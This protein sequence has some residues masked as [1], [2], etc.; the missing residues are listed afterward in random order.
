M[1]DF[2]RDNYETYGKELGLCRFG[3]ASDRC[4]IVFDESYLEVIKNEGKY[5][6]GIL[7]G[8]W[9]IHQYN[10]K[11][12][13]GIKSPFILRGE[14]WRKGRMAINPYLFNIK[15]AQSYLGAINKTAETV[16]TKFEEYASI[17]KLDKF[18]EFAAFDMF[19]AASLGLQVNSVAGEPWAVDL[20]ERVNGSF[21]VMS[22]VA[23]NCPYSK[24][25][26]F[27]FKQW[28]KFVAKWKA[29]REASK[30]LI[31]RALEKGEGDGKG[32]MHGFMNDPDLEISSTE[33]TEMNLILTLAAADTTSS[34]INNVLTN[35]S[36]HPDIQDKVR[37][38]FRR[39]LKGAD[40]DPD[41]KLEYFEQVLKETQ[42]LTPPLAFVNVKSEIDEE[43][44][45]NGFHV[46][47]GTTV[48]F[49]H[50]GIA[51]DETFAG[52]EPSK[53]NPDRFSEE[54]IAARKGTRAAFLDHPICH[55]PFGFGARMCVGS[56]IAKLEYTSLICRLLQDYKIEYDPD[57]S[58]PS[59][60]VTQTTTTEQPCPAFKVARV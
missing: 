12:V 37:C 9:P 13:D 45:L 46:P 35:L 20:F 5:P 60:R 47:K 26:M 8:S 32:I 40:Y 57:R 33:A 30:E 50:M 7:E 27:K 14:A 48:A 6:V 1:E 23:T 29:G 51:N 22:T 55:K 17:G 43:L 53:F 59:I 41:A 56:R 49:S 34:L 25:D 54:A 28:D 24:Y 2:M 10:E 11:Y 4:V 3:P 52:P 58:A 31:Q 16:S 39:E 18:C 42:R 38:E 19:A 21:S 44:V 36:R 15:A